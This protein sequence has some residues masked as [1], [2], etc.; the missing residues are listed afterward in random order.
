MV[1]FVDHTPRLGDVQFYDPPYFKREFPIRGLN[2][3]LNRAFPNFIRRSSHSHFQ[4]TNSSWTCPS[5]IPSIPSGE[6]WN[7]YA[8]TASRGSFGGG[9]TIFLVDG[10]GQSGSCS[11]FSLLVIG[12]LKTRRD[13]NE[14]AN[15]IASC[16][17]CGYRLYIGCSSLDDAEHCKT[18]SRDPPKTASTGIVTLSLARKLEDTTMIPRSTVFG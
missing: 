2:L 10:W 5:G 16:G 4:Q 6:S 1:P 7:S 17:S 14:F 12:S 3:I 9:V 15:L 18:K 11:L 13:R 8:A